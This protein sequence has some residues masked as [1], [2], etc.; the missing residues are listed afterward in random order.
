MRS[1]SVDGSFP[2][3]LLQNGADPNALESNG[4]STL[5][6]AVTYRDNAAVII[7]DLLRCG[8]GPNTE[9]HDGTCVLYYL[10]VH[11]FPDLGKQLLSLGLNPEAGNEHGQTPVVHQ[12]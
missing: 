5:H 12:R 9:H 6:S 4:T 8:A 10:Q 1:V 7:A 2:Y 3:A 11:G